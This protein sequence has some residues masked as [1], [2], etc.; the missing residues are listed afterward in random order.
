MSGRPDHQPRSLKPP[1]PLAKQAAKRAAKGSSTATPHRLLLAEIL[2]V[3]VVLGI[4]ALMIIPRLASARNTEFELTIR[5]QLLQLRTQILAYQAQH[6]GLAP[7]YP[8]GD[9]AAK[10]TYEAF[11]AQATQYTNSRGQVSAAASD[12]YNLGPYLKQIP[13]N[14]VNQKPQLLFIGSVEEAGSVAD[15]RPDVGWLYHPPT[16]TIVANLPGEDLHGTRYIDF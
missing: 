6:N 4:L 9:P 2:I 1:P 11:V 5:D 13:V 3:G 14:P 7:G 12:Q 8:N 10:P 16:G 15:Q